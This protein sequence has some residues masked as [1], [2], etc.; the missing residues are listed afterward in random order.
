MTPDSFGDRIAASSGAT[1]AVSDGSAV[2]AT[3]SSDTDSGTPLRSTMSPR[4]ACR[5][6]GLVFSFV[7]A[8]AYE[9]GSTPC[10]R[11][12]RP[13]NSDSTNAITPSVIRSRNV[14]RPSF[15]VRGGRLTFGFRTGGRRFCGGLFRGAAAFFPTAF[16]AAA[17]FSGRPSGPYGEA[18]AA[19]HSPRSLP[20]AGWAQPSWPPSAAHHRA[21]DVRVCTLRSACTRRRRLALAARSGATAFCSGGTA[22]LSLAGR[23]APLRLTATSAWRLV[24]PSL[25]HPI[26][27]RWSWCSLLSPAAWWCPPAA[28]WCWCS[29][30]WSPFQR[31][32][33]WCRRAA[34][35]YRRA[36]S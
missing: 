10:N 35:S 15:N 1:L 6:N 33:W 20:A 13:A 11:I 16:L 25:R 3:A 8:S 14:G 22:G 9:S 12:S 21:H 30:C 36:A 27:P 31:A 7:A 5:T 24:A 4:E 29:A 23:G 17:F 32:A 34:S 28:C 2:I 18:P 19:P 26:I